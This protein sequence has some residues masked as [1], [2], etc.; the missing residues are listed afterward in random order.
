MATVVCRRTSVTRHRVSK[1]SFRDC[2]HVTKFS[3]IFFIFNIGPIFCLTLCQW[4]RA[5]YR[6]EWVHN[7]LLTAY[8]ADIK[9]EKIGL[10]FVTCE[11]SLTLSGSECESNFFIWSLW[12]SNWIHSEAN[13]L[14]FRLIVAKYYIT[15]P[16]RVCESNLTSSFTERFYSRSDLR[17]GSGDSGESE[18]AILRAGRVRCT[19]Q[20]GAHVQHNH[21][22][23]YRIRP[24]SRYGKGSFILTDCESDFFFDLC[25]C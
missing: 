22:H 5:E 13:Q 16:S 8:Q 25:R 9:N 20:R 6:A 23:R 21:H 12:T 3:P 2:S 7:P 11:Q 10:N 18:P 19:S 15:L 14:A 17:D 4:W 24:W 1:G